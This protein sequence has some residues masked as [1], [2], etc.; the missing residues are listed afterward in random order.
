M[1]PGIDGYTVCRKL[2]ASDN[3]HH[4]PVI[5]V[6]GKDAMEDRLEGYDAGGDDFLV[7]PVSL[8]ELRQ[9]VGVVLRYAEQ[10]RSLSQNVDSAFR[11]AMTAMS[12]AAEMGVV[13]HFFR[14]SFSTQ[15]YAALGRQILGAMSQL[16]LDSSVQLRSRYGEHNLTAEGLCSPLEASILSNVRASGRIVDLGARTAINYER[17]TLLAKNMPRED[18]DRYGRLRDALALLAEGID[19]RIK[20]LDD[21]ESLTRRNR[22]LTQVAATAARI[23]SDLDFHLRQ[24]DI[25][26]TMQIR[27]LVGDVSE[28]LVFLGISAR[29]ATVLRQVITTAED[30]IVEV[31][32]LHGA[33]QADINRLLA[34]VKGLADDGITPP[35]DAIA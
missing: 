9:K 7:K 5:F 29:E 1:M 15:T 33:I 2:R 10:N 14:E 34:A 25:R 13:L 26:H 32:D 16:G 19:A 12:S 8:A 35:D 23:Q 4:L 17:V 22:A 21:E 31:G 11:T 20:G 28:A 6:S 18:V 3:H 30:Q 27:K 24:L